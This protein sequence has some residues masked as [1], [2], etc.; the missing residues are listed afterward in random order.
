MEAKIVK[1]RP[2]NYIE[3]KWYDINLMLGTTKVPVL[4][5]KC[6]TA[7]ILDRYCAILEVEIFVDIA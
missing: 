6:D 5:H 2:I 1:Q 7:S 3:F 4:V